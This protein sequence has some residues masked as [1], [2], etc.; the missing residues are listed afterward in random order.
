ML[1]SAHSPLVQL[2]LR[3]GTWCASRC[4]PVPVVTLTPTGIAVCQI[5]VARQLDDA[6]ESL[7]V[8]TYH[9]LVNYEIRVFKYAFVYVFEV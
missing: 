7:F 8:A 4:E 2:S 6:D 1:M 9:R 5:A 3:S